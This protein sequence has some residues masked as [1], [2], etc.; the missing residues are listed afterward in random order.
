MLP[1]V[2]AA[3]TELSKELSAEEVASIRSH[4]AEVSAA[5]ES[6]DSRRLKQGLATLDNATQTL[7]TRLI[8]KSVTS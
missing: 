3:L 7:A 5:L 1:A 4:V 2:E 6:K 8:E